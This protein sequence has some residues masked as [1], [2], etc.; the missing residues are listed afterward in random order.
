M[1]DLIAF[2]KARL[3]EDEHVARAVAW[4]DR[5]ACWRV[6]PTG[7]VSGLGIVVER[8]VYMITGQRHDKLEHIA[9]H[10][11]ARVLREV[12]AKRRI[13]ESYVTAQAKVDR[14]VG[15]DETVVAGRAWREGA[16]LEVLRTLALPYDDHDDYREEWKP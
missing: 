3:D 8:D 13:V 5:A 12:E 7:V 2:L 6:A 1:D 10:D 4:T 14:L 16:L 11:P 15:E 9:R